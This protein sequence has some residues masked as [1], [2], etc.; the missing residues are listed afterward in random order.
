MIDL[1]EGNGKKSSLGAFALRYAL[2]PFF[3]F[4]AL[5]S[6]LIY[7]FCLVYVYLCLSRLV[8]GFLYVLKH[9]RLLDFTFLVIALFLCWLGFLGKDLHMHDLACACRLNS[10]RRRPIL[11]AWCCYLKNLDFCLFW[12]CLHL[13]ICIVSYSRFLT[14]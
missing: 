2:K 4:F 8:L 12:V 6:V 10:C 11:V 9:A 13:F 14:S 5:T 3:F 7:F 1:T